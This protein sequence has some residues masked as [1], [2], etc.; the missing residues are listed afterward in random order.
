M[1]IEF[2]EGNCR[3]KRPAQQQTPQSLRDVY[4]PSS[5]F[6][7]LKKYNFQVGKQKKEI[8]LLGFLGP[9]FKPIGKVDTRFIYV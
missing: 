2:D 4:L 1:K 8:L 7:F 6:L 9:S 3:G 5:H